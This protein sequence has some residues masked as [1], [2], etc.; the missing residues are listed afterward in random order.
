MV[1]PREEFLGNIT[2]LDKDNE[3]IITCNSA[4][5]QDVF[6]V[7]HTA[8]ASA[9]ISYAAG[10]GI[11]W[12][13]DTTPSLPKFT[14]SSG[15]TITLGAS[16]ATPT[17]GEVLA[18]GNTTDGYNIEVYNST[19]VP[20]SDSSFGGYLYAEAGAGKWR[21]SSGTVTTFG[22][23][24]PHCPTCGRDFGH[25]WENKKTSEV[26]RICVPCML[27]KLDNAGIDTSFAYTRDLR[28]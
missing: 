10:N 20:S 21:G 4:F 1:L 3:G 17:L 18:E 26:L 22:P 16:L 24:E 14:D 15:T 8:R 27:E 2:N 25:E 5:I 19:S 9:P 6:G 7:L 13:E 23:A 11:F 28:D 12:V